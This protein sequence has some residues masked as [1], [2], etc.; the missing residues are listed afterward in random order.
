MSA[1]SPIHLV[2]LI[3]LPYQWPILFLKF[4]IMYF[5]SILCIRH[6]HSEHFVLKHL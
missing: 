5:S 2:L 6:K 1:A 3:S 4:I